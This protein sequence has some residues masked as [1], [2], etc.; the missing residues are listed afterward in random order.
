[1]LTFVWW[2]GSDCKGQIQKQTDGT[3]SNI[4]VFFLLLETYHSKK[5]KKMHAVSIIHN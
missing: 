3:L 2:F 4:G 5:K 1:M